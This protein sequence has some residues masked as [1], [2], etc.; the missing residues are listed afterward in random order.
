MYQVMSWLKR[1]LPYK[2]IKSHCKPSEF[3]LPHSSLA[4]TGWE[5]KGLECAKI[6]EIIGFLWKQIWVGGGM[7]YGGTFYT[8]GCNSSWERISLVA[9]ELV[10]MCEVLYLFGKNLNCSS[11][12]MG[13]RGWSQVIEEN[14]LPYSSPKRVLRV[15][16]TR[17]ARWKEEQ[18]M[19]C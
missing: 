18:V 19:F 16:N 1:H 11:E 15:V 17:T 12:M 10:K 8:G 13:Y 9:A 3:P 2:K 7:D 14:C 6:L 5:A 4:L